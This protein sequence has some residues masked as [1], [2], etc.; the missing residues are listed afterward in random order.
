MKFQFNKGY[1]FMSIALFC[2]EVF[3]GV[4][5]HDALIRPYG[6]DF[7][8]VI[9][10]YCVLQSFIAVKLRPA[11]LLVLFTAYAIEVS[12]YFHLINWLGLEH[13]LAARLILG[14]SFSWTDMLCYTLGITLVV[15][16]E[17]CRSQYIYRR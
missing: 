4:Y 7:L 6:G 11:V 12:Q 3:I 8:V 2:T 16:I 9:L 14:T 17:V 1:F 13:S 10:L 5:A 15:F